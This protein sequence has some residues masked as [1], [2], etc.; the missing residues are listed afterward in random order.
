MNSRQIAVVTGGSQGIGL[1]IAEKLV[2]DEYLVIDA[3]IHPPEI[4]CKEGIFYK[5]C[6][7]SDSASVS[8]LINTILKE[9]NRIDILV[10]NAGIIRDNLILNMSEED[11]DQVIRVNLKGTWLMCKH[12]APVM[13]K[14]NFGRIINIAS[15]AWLGNRGQSN[16]SSAKAGVVALSRVLALEL[17]KYNIT[18]NT[19]APG[20][21]A[22]PLTNKLDHAVL[23]GLI[24]AQPGKN[25]GQPED[26]AEAVAFLANKK[27]K[28][29]NGQLLYVDGGKSVLS[30][31]V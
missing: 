18:V 25:I 5:H 24:N 11:F 14:Q 9:F 22:T 10:N 7:V 20:L 21:I 8:L 4:N 3:D 12:V 30:S 17:G 26:V 15:R 16:Y 29:I 19:V 13:K 6:N 31:L 28:F 23:E 1:S 2:E 27:N